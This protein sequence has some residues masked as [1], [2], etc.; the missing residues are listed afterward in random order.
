MAAVAMSNMGDLQQVTTQ[1]VTTAIVA[2]VG[3]LVLSWLGWFAIAR[4]RKGLMKD[5]EAG[6][7]WSLDD[8]QEMRD[9]GQL[10]EQ[11]YKVLRQTL[12]HEKMGATGG[13]KGKQDPPGDRNDKISR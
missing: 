13:T 5:S 4:Y 8:L 2:M 11:E 10:T 7:P 12:I 3:V 1:Q 6:G 9:S